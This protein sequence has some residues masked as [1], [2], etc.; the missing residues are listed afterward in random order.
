MKKKENGKRLSHKQRVRVSRGKERAV[1]VV[2]RM[3]RRRE[4]DR[5]RR[6][7]AVSDSFSFFFLSRLRLRLSGCGLG[8]LTARYMYR[9]TG[10]S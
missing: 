1:G 2:E 10:T 5:G 4:R 9:Q 7:R 8:K 6:G 3:E